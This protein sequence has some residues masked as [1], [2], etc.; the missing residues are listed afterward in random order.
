MNSEKSW[1]FIIK[2]RCVNQGQ[3]FLIIIFW[4]GKMALVD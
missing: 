4:I 1:V 2:I 3:T